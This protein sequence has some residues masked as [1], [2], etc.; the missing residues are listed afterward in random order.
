[1]TNAFQILKMTHFSQILLRKKFDKMITLCAGFF[2][3]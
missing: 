1:M 2:T 3:V